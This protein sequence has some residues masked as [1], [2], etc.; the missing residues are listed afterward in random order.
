MAQL[1]ED[2]LCMMGKCYYMSCFHFPADCQVEHHVLGFFRPLI[3]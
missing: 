1:Q 2:L 3:N